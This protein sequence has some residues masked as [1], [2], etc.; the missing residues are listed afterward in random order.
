MVAAVAGPGE[1]LANESTFETLS[2]I[3]QQFPWLQKCLSTNGFFLADKL[4]ILKQLEVRTITITINAI[5][6]AIGKQIYSWVKVGDDVLS[7]ETGA[8]MLIERQLWGLE[9]AVQQGFIIK[10]NSVL[11]PTI[12]E[13]HLIQVARKIAGLGAYIHN[14]LPLIPQ[15]EF[16][17]LHAPSVRQLLVVRTACEPVIKQKWHCKQCRADAVGLI[18]QG[19]TLADLAA[20]GAKSSCSATKEPATCTTVLPELT[21][22][23]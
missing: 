12:N 22:L 11:I 2:L 6:P 20:A 21:S 18:G 23:D 8:A 10:V 4:D 15:S 17:H 7:G 13:N 16:A 1:P 3:H 19:L 5:D 9:L 14:I